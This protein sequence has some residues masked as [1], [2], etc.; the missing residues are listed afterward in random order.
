MSTER[1][2]IPK[3]GENLPY[4]KLRVGSC[5]WKQIIMSKT[6]FI[7]GGSRGLGRDSAIRLAEKGFDIILTY[8]VQKEKAEEAK[9]A[10]EELG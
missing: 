1:L 3:R 9:A 7:T 10:I 5:S 8:R 2:F 4:F 6:A